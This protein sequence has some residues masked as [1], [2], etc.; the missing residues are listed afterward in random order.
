MRDADESVTEDEAHRQLENIVISADGY[1]TCLVVTLTPEAARRP[2]RAL[3]RIER[4][5]KTIPGLED[6]QLK[7]FGPPIYV[8]TVN[9]ISGQLTLY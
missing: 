4:E 8:A 3:Q 9:S 1:T 5:A 2:T 6:E 7:M